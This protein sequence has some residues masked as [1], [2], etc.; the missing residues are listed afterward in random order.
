[1]LDQGLKPENIALAGDS[2]GGNLVLTTM[3]GLRE[4]GLPLPAETPAT[5]QERGWSSPIWYTPPKS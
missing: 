5:I 4:R 1:M 3:L 2:A